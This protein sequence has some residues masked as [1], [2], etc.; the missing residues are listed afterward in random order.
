MCSQSIWWQDTHELLWQAAHRLLHVGH[1]ICGRDFLSFAQS[2]ASLVATFGA[3]NRRSFAASTGGWSWSS[4]SHSL[5]GLV[6]IVVSLMHESEMHND[7]KMNPRGH[8]PPQLSLC[9]PPLC[10][11]CR[12]SRCR[13]RLHLLRDSSLDE[14]CWSSSHG[15]SFQPAG[16]R[17]RDKSRLRP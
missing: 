15:T 12:R 9:H 6:R 13:R 7:G 8:L 1:S 5:V 14:C 10:L 16:S 3:C 2:F 17:L 4:S 11:H